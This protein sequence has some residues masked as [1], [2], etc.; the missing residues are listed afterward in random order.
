MSDWEERFLFVVKKVNGEL[1]LNGGNLNHRKEATMWCVVE[2]DKIY[3]WADF[4]EIKLYVYDFEYF[5]NETY[6]YS[7]HYSFHRV[8]PDFH[9]HSCEMYGFGIIDYNNT[10]KE[11]DAAGLQSYEQNKV[12]W[13]GAIS[14]VNRDIL[15]EI[16]DKNKELFDFKRYTNWH[17]N[18]QN[19]L[20]DPNSK[21]EVSNYIS[22][23]DLVKL[24][25]ILID[26]EGEGYSGRVK[27]LLWSHRPLLLQDRPHKEYFYEYL[28]EW[29]HYIPV[30][31]DL[32]DLVEKTQWCMNNYSEA[33]KIA[34][35]AYQFAKK[36]LT[37]EACYAQ[38]NKIITEHINS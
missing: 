26:V 16:G 13:I 30:K 9:F 14:H 11:I 23:P 7:K 4:A 25:S 10:I 28:K 17:Y 2:A 18:K 6:T 15:L 36:Y 3:K 34:E 38:W 31:R 12:G 8:I 29:D 20:P 1:I 35:N 37:R 22:T 33:L 24:Y 32:S 21:Y 19:L 27:Y 5:G